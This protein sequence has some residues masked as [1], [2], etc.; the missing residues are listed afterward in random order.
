MSLKTIFQ[1]IGEWD[2]YMESHGAYPWWK[3][4]GL[5]FWWVWRPLAVVAVGILV[6]VPVLALW[7]LADLVLGTYRNLWI[8]TVAAWIVIWALIG[9]WR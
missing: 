2:S 6:A 1:R 8:G 9:F 3:P 4:C 7:M 5:L